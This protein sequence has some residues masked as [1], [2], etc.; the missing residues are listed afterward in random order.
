MEKPTRTRENQ[1][2][3]EKLSTRVIKTG[4]TDIKN[5]ILS[6]TNGGRNSGEKGKRTSSAF[7][8]VI[9]SVRNT[10]KH[11]STHPAGP[12]FHS[13]DESQMR[14]NLNE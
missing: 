2:V 11:S 7:I 12:A 5:F 4:I 6:R 14:A 3:E 10:T 1:R 8:T 9:A 13:V